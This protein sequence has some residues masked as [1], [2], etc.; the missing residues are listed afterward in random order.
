VVF[1]KSDTNVLSLWVLPRVAI[2]PYVARLC[3]EDAVIAAKFAIL[4]GEPRCAS[5][6]KDDV[7]WDDILAYNAISLADLT[8]CL[9]K[10]THLHSSW[11]LTVYRVHLLLRWLVL[12]LDA[13]SAL[14]RRGP[15]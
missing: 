6:P 12:G 3:S 10:Q 4:A 9:D 1:L 13:P 5:L 7:S 14:R 11:L 8:S 2:V 15:G